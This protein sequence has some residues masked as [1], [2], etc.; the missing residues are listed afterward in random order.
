MGV[1]SC[2]QEFSSQRVRAGIQ[3][4]IYGCSGTDN[5][6]EL[7]ERLAEGEKLETLEEYDKNLVRK[8]L[9]ESRRL[10][11]QLTLSLTTTEG[12]QQVLVRGGLKRDKDGVGT[13]TQLVKH[14]EFTAKG[15]RAQE[16]H[17]KWENETLRPEEHPELLY[18]RLFVI[19]FYRG[20][21]ILN[22]PCNISNL[23]EFLAYVHVSKSQVTDL[24]TMKGLASVPGCSHC[25]KVGH[26]ERECWSKHPRNKRTQKKANKYIPK[27]GQCWECG[28][29][30]C[31]IGRHGR[32]NICSGDSY[33]VHL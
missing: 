9:A 27:P 28:Q 7:V 16:V 29:A 4:R 1:R 33:A 25:G 20:Q 2:Q 15:L 6:I 18:V 10:K 17:G 23:R 11:T 30:C 12:A 19:T 21:M 24:P 22:N 5:A 26:S 8:G 13:W 14:F 31:I 3:G 32:E